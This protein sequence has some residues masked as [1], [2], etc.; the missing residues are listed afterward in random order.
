VMFTIPF[1]FALYPELLLIDKAVID[2]NNGLFLSGYDGSINFGWLLLLMLRI[3]VAL[4]LVSSA[5]AA[6]DRKALKPIEIAAR[7][8]IAVLILARPIE[9]YG[10]ALVAGVALVGWH[11]LRSKDAV[12]A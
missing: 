5:L 11:T 3:A 10:V 1:V 7:L 2:P 9:I 12:P 8:A 4:Y 6:F